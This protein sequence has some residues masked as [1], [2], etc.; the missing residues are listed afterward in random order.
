MLEARGFRPNSLVNGRSSGWLISPLSA[1]K[2]EIRN[3][4][5][6][7]TCLINSTLLLVQI[8]YGIHTN[9]KKLDFPL[10]SRLSR[11]YAEYENG[12]LL[13]DALI[14]TNGILNVRRVRTLIPQE[15]LG[16][17][18]FGNPERGFSGTLPI[19]S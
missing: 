14:C 8:G 12:L 4:F 19:V 10:F 16:F 17:F 2:R 13:A 7:D 1:L 6:Q 11:S 3:S 15:N 9:L 5:F 18:L